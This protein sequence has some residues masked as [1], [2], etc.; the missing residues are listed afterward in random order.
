MLAERIISSVTHSIGLMSVRITNKGDV[1]SLGVIFYQMLYGKRPF[2]HGQMQE[3]FLA[4]NVVLN[5]MKVNFP[6]SPRISEEA[7]SFIR[8]AWRDQVCRP[9]IAELCKSSYLQKE[10]GVIIPCCTI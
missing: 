8:K 4:N 10:N 7:K 3:G 9:S 6:D 5:A 2:G 1:W